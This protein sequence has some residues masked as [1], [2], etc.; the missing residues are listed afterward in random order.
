MSAPL[1]KNVK[2]DFPDTMT[3]EQRTKGSEGAS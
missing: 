1:Q 3:F 2:R